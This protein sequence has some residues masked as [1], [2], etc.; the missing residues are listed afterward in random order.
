MIVNKRA[1]EIAM[2]EQGFD[3]IDLAEKMCVSRQVVYKYLAGESCRP[4]MARQFA[5]ALAVPV[6]DLFECEPDDIGGQT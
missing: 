5:D 6:R 4:K 2:A 3:K 1:A